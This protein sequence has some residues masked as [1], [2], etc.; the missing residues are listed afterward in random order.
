MPDKRPNKQRRSQGHEGERNKRALF[1][2]RTS[3]LLGL[4]QTEVED[5]LQPRLTHSGRVNRLRSDDSQK[6]IDELASAGMKM[7]PLSWYPDGFTFTATKT[8]VAQTSAVTEGR[9]FIQNASS[10]LPPVALQARPG[11][12]VLDACA[13]PGGKA[14][15]VAAL[16]EGR[17]SLWMNDGIPS[18]IGRIEDV[19]RTLGFVPERLTTFPAQYLDKY[20]TEEFDGILLDA[21]CSGEGQLD[22][23]FSTAF[24]YWSLARILKYRH[25]QTKMLV[26]AFRLLRPGGVLIYSTCTL[27]PEE[28]EAPVSTLL[29]RESDAAVEPLAFD[30]PAAR[31]AVTRWEGESVHP[32]VGGGLRLAPD[33]VME[34]F[35]VCRIRKIGGDLARSDLKEL[36]LGAEARSQVP[37]RPGG[38]PI[39]SP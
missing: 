6:V 19:A 15:H 21:Q 4:S 35:F 1:L 24:R 25:L 3:G 16:T 31:A 8:S 10:F 2:R 36:D 27:A 39:A 34:A 30:H 28:N 26:S 11:D 9:F 17:A 37:I 29:Q 23:S 13:A 20:V 32:A 22:L 38:P 18:R 7:S 33:S 14:S 5:R 12:A